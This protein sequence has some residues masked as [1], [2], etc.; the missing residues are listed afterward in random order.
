MSALVGFLIGLACGG[1]LM[2]VAMLLIFN[3]DTK[4]RRY[5]DY[6]AE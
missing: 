1:I 4:Q 2:F 5:P 6:G 3:R